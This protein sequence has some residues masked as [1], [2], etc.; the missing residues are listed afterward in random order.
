MV[1]PARRVADEVAADAAAI[2]GAGELVLAGHVAYEITAEAAAAAIEGARAG[3]LAAGRL[4]RA[5]AAG[6][7]AAIRAVQGAFPASGLALT[8]ATEASPR[9]DLA[10][11]GSHLAL[12][13]AVPAVR[14]AER[15]GGADGGHAR[16]ACGIE[17]DPRH[18]FVVGA[19]D[20]RAVERAR[21]LVF[22][23][24]RLAAA[25]TAQAVWRAV[26]RA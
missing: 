4:T 10:T 12:T 16:I 14:A 7:S 5:I 9:A 26:D 13:D 25:V 8:V 18:A 6:A 24:A 21:V 22:T 1:F 19:W 2:I 23:A 3:V 11:D 20:E 17:G 15:V